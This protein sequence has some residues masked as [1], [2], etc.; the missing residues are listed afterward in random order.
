MPD[1]RGPRSISGLIHAAADR[2]RHVAQ[3]AGGQVPE[4]S[5]LA[6]SVRSQQAPRPRTGTDL[7][8]IA[9]GSVTFEFT[10]IEVRS[11]EFVAGSGQYEWTVNI[12]SDSPQDVCYVSGQCGSGTVSVFGPLARL[13]PNGDALNFTLIGGNEMFVAVQPASYNTE[14][15]SFLVQVAAWAKPAAITQAP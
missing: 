6:A 14:A 15:D 2:T 12:R 8:I 1:R 3:S 13:N 11:A 7:D 4:L 10:E 9:F 5:R